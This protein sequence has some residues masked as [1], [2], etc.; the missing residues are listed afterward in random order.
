MENNTDKLVRLHD[1]LNCMK[2][3]TRARRVLCNF[4]ND[5]TDIPFLVKLKNKIQDCENEL[6][7]LGVMK[8]FQNPD[9]TKYA[10]FPK[11]L[12]GC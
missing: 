6:I 1:M 7:T 9:G 8:Y 10:D 3:Q 5:D 4:S 12:K 11:A 2:D